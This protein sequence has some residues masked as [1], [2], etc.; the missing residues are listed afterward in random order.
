M[1]PVSGIVAFP[2]GTP[3]DHGILQLRHVDRPLLAKGE[4]DAQG[5][6]RLSTRT[7]GDGVEPGKYRGAIV[8]LILTE[9]L[10]FEQHHH[11]KR[12]DPKYANFD[13]ADL[14]FEFTLEG[15]REIRI[16]V[17]EPPSH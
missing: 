7:P 5:R 17:S 13:A 3:L 8:Q 4:I 2:D 9:E 15:P 16:T 12:L 1:V 14:S 11:A 10:S 6:F